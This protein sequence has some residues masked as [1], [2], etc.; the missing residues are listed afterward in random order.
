MAYS[1]SNE[2]AAAAFV[3]AIKEIAQ[4]PENLNNLES[5]LIYNFP[6]WLAREA[7]TPEDLAAEMQE[8]AQ[9]EF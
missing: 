7:S 2:K 1:K 3:A 6:V 5:Y 8:F 9:M 4:K